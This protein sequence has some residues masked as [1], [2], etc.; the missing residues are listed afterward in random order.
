MR[1]LPTLKWVERAWE[2]LSHLGVE[3]HDRV[4]ARYIM[5]A[6]H[7]M[8]LA[9]LVSLVRAVSF[10]FTFAPEHWAPA[11]AHLLLVVTWIGCLVLNARGW[12]VASSVIGLLAP[13]LHFTWLSWQFS[14]DAGFQLVLLTVGGLAIAVLPPTLRWVR[15]GFAVVATAAAL[16]VYFGQPFV[17]GEIAVDSTTMSQ[18]LMGNV[19]SAVLLV[20]LL[21]A[22]SDFYLLRER[23]LAGALIDQAEVAAKTDTLTGVLNRRGLAPLLAAA[24]RDG[25]YAL[26]LADLD[27]FKRIND[28]L[29]HGTGDVVLAN[30]ARRLS[31][32]V[33]DEGVVSRWGGEEFLILLPNMTATHAMQ[34]MERARV[35]VARDFGADGVMDHVTLSAGVAHVPQGTSKEDALRIADRLLYE[36]KDAGRN[37]VL[38]TA[39]VGMRHTFPE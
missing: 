12:F 23:R 2:K 3:G 33:G 21:V 29:G 37:R 35:A 24:V 27:R 36:A 38:A 13:L 20:T 39:V 30:V 25:D 17:E 9:I 8:V 18:L 5:G 26:A 16:W 19:V 10:A 4:A 34:V 14:A 6:N 1:R 11:L 31:V 32:A 15:A 7:F 28:R 22:F